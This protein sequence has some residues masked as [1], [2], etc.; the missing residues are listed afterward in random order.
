V[1][2]EGQLQHPTTELA[3]RL[4]ALTFAAGRHDAAKHL[5]QSWLDAH[6]DAL[7]ARLALADEATGDKRQALDLLERVVASNDTFDGKDDARR[8]LA[9]L[10]RD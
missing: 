7:P 1:L 9:A 4:A 2:K 5:L 3:V 8:H 10:R 6:D